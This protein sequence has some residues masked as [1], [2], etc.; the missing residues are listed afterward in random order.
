[1]RNSHVALAIGAF[2]AF[3]IA[4]GK[5]SA[6]QITIQL[7]TIGVFNVNTVVSVPDGGTVSLG[8]V[9]RYSSGQISRGVPGAS[10]LPYASRLFRNQAIGSTASNANTN[11]N[12][13]IISLKEMEDEL[14]AGHQAT[15]FQN[16]NGNAAI[17]TKADFLSKHMGRTQKR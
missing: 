15:S 1:M 7:P 5:E 13:Q 9:N 11:V 17:R 2:L 4:S 6:A 14:L 12:V 3:S 16:P 10:N 8:G